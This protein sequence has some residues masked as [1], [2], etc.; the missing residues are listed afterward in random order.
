MSQPIPRFRDVRHFRD[1]KATPV[2]RHWICDAVGC[3]GE[4]KCVGR[5]VTMFETRWEHHCTKCGRT[6][7]ADYT[8]P[9]IAFLPMEAID[10]AND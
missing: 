8:Y 9:R 10:A 5:G 7:F 1:E 4:M 6:D 2:W 3:D